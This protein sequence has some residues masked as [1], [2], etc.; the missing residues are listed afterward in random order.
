[1]T[2]LPSSS[3]EI[4]DREDADDRLNGWRLDDGSIGIRVTEGTETAIVYV[5]QADEARLKEWLR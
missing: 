3:I 4:R 2:E 1:M 5:S